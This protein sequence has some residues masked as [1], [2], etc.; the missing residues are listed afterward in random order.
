MY[1]TQTE[2]DPKPDLLANPNQRR[3]KAF[4]P[5]T[6]PIDHLQEHVREEVQALQRVV[7]AKHVE[8]GSFG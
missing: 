8:R 4:M 7:T 2:S 6:R 3:D 1:I 5:H